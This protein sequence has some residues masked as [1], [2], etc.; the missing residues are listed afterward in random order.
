[1]TKLF[2]KGGIAYAKNDL[3]QLKK[4]ATLSLKKFHKNTQNFT[5]LF[6]ASITCNGYLD[7]THI[8]LFGESDLNRLVYTLTNTKHWSEERI[9]LFGGSILLLPPK[10]IYS[11]ASLVISE[12]N[13]KKKIS[14]FQFSNTYE[15]LLNAVLALIEKKQLKLAKKLLINLDIVQLQERFTITL[16]RKRFLHAL[17]VFCTTQDSTEIN[18]IFSILDWLHMYQTLSDYNFALRKIKKAYLIN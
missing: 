6:D 18:G 16:I 10:K 8:N 14:A 17:I 7:L 5:N 11:I 1:M 15:M 2:K 4:L 13:S 3:K 9:E 12:L